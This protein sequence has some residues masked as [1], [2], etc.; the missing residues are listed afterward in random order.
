MAY[1]LVLDGVRQGQQWEVDRR[2]TLGRHQQ[3]LL[4]FPG[5]LVSRFHATVEPAPDG[6]CWLQ[7]QGS[8]AGTL[9]NGERVTRKS[10][11]GGDEI[12]IGDV[13]LRFVE[14]DL[15]GAEDL[16]ETLEATQPMDQDTPF[17]FG[18]RAGTAAQLYDEILEYLLSIV[19][20]QRGL[21][22]LLQTG[23]AEPVQVAERTTG[24]PMSPE[25]SGIEQALVSKALASG[26]ALFVPSRIRQ[27]AQNPRHA[28]QL[29]DTRCSI[30]AP[31]LAPGGEVLG[32]IYLDS[33]DVFH[34]LDRR[35]VQWIEAA[36]EPAARAIV[37][38][39]AG[40]VTVTNE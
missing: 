4:Q 3:N 31:L 23:A 10:L 2:L 14:G 25:I 15:A 20:A 6:L 33:W 7:D 27:F 35:Q 24:A 9:V 28:I 21:I 26:A 22:L 1:L 12:T 19:P 38:S 17:E 40:T 36:A 30:I 18:K 39:S 32:V 29:G 8:T 37:L 16:G 5:G 34:Q 13:R 11:C